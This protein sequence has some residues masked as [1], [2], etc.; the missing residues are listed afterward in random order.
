MK[1]HYYLSVFPTE[2]L[3]ASQLEP[4]RFGQYMAIGSKNGSY[5]KIMFIELE[6]DFG[7]FFDWKYAKE[8]C[9]PHSNGDP[10]NSVWMSV[11]RALE[12][13]PVDKLRSMFLTTIDGRTLEIP[14]SDFVAPSV[15][16]EYYVYQELCPVTPLVVSALNPAEFAAYMT[17]PKSHVQVPS[18][19]FADLKVIDF[20]N[21]EKTGNIGATYDKNL[22]HLKQ[23]IHA[24]T[25]HSG[26]VN[27]NV[28]RSNVGSFGYQI[29]SQGIYVGNAAKIAMYKMPTI[30]QVRQN[31][32]DWGRSAMIL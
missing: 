17:D 18:L 12:H 5:E 22:E 1:T 9:V 23:C 24:V 7:D 13:T 26:K 16:K 8:R 19:V 20:G 30:E 28:E 29:I 10:K 4:A 21:P 6:G 15:K 27:K 2:A 31:H 25:E 14:R 11:Y 32:Y 3:I